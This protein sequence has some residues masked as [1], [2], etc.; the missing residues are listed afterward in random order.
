MRQKGISL[1]LDRKIE[2]PSQQCGG[3]F[4]LY[5]FAIKPLNCGLFI[6]PIFEIS[7]IAI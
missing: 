7:K 4:L 3:I 6:L 2:I 5:D 1:P